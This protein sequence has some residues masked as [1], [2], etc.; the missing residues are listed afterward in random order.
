LREQAKKRLAYLHT[1]LNESRSG[2]A[3]DELRTN[4]CSEI[5]LLPEQFCNLTEVIVRP[6]DSLTRLIEKVRLATIMGT[7]QASLTNFPNLREQWKMNSDA[8]A[9][10]GVSLSGVMDHEVLNA[11][12]YIRHNDTNVVYWLKALKRHARLTN[13][14]FAPICGVNVSHAITCVKP[15]GTVSQVVN[16]AS[17]IHARYARHY[18]R[19][20]RANVTDPLAQMMRD[21]KIPCEPCVYKPTD[22]LVFSFPIKAPE[23]SVLTSEYSAVDQLLV[24]QLYQENY[25][26]HKP[27]VTIQV[28]AHEWESVREFVWEQFDTMT[29]VAFLP[30]S[31]HTY[32]QAPYQEVSEQE[33]L[34]ALAKMPK[35]IDWTQLHRYEEDRT[36]TERLDEEAKRMSETFACT[37]NGCDNVD[38]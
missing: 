23:S 15:S 30:Y 24:W 6:G 36:E 38:I 16:C 20:V 17:G 1:R 4:P 13:E 34:S 26:E 28:R 10:L 7:M 21:Q 5:L 27:S 32:K 19:T 2:T 18:I 29:G 22:T 3:D 8:E 37:A 9:L 33:Y 11:R 35:R 12:A 25:C 31:E 14:K